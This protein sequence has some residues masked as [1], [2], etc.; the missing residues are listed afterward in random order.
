M[1]FRSMDGGTVDVVANGE[2]S[3]NGAIGVSGA[4]GSLNPQLVQNLA[5]SRFCAAQ[6]G[7]RFIRVPHSPETHD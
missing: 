4:A 6:L 5:P 3:E 1:P 7:H 2:R